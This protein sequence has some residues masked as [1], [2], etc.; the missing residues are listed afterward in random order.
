LITGARAPVALDC[1]LSF[2][3]AGF[4]VH[5]ADSITPYA[6]QLSRRRWTVHPL[7]PPRYRFAEF[8]HAMIAL[9][10]RLK[11]ELVVPTCEEVFYVAAALENAPLFAPNLTLLRR[12]HSKY[13]F[14]QLAR[15]AGVTTPATWLVKR[16][17][18]LQGLNGRDLVLKPEFSRFASATLI[19][20]DAATMAALRPSPLRA[21]VAQQFI[22]GEEICSWS[23]VRDGAVTAHV[24]Y[25]PAWR[26]GHAAS[27]AFEAIDCP[28]MAAIAHR[29]A[30]ATGMTGHLSF[31]A[32]LSGGQVLPIECNPRAVSGLHLFD[33]DGDMAMAMLG[34]AQASVPQGRLRYLSPAMILLGLPSALRRHRLETFRRDWRRG[35]DVTGRN[36]DWPSRLGS[37]LDAVRFAAAGW[38]RGIR[39]Q[40]TDD[41]EWNGEPIA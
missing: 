41:I 3:H 12:L 14:A 38:R 21:W 28:P 34:R 2:A 30:A 33:A 7:P 8:R 31:D 18:D 22:P 11:P 1:A 17:E 36:R 29:I 27:Y 10:G 39:A 20:P 25:R 40:T 23:A 16:P 19:R 9:V 26:H 24:T 37:V 15:E 35:A 5:L 32:I 13:E 6:A 4:E